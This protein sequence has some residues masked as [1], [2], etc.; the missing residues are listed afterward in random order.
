MIP[1]DDRAIDWE[2]RAT[3]PGV[4][5]ILMR[6][7]L[8]SRIVDELATCLADGDAHGDNPGR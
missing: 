2:F 6:P 5:R 1:F 8:P 4:R 7:I 3:R